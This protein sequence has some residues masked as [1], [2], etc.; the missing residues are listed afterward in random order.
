MVDFSFIEDPDLR[1][2]AENVAKIKIDQLTVDLSN[3]AKSQIEEAVAGLKAKNTEILTEKKTLQETLKK[4]EGYDPKVI[5]EATEFYE[6]NKDA[7]FLKDGTVEELIEKKTSQLTSDFEAQL[8]ELNE[9]LQKAQ[10]HG[11]TYQQLFEAKV[12]DDGIREEALKAGML[13]SAIE[14]AILRGRGIFSLDENKQIEA[15]DAEGKLAI[16]EDKKVLTTKNWIEGL[17]TTSPHY[18]PQSTSAN[19][20]GGRSGDMTDIMA[21]KIAAAE[22]GDVNAYR[23]LRDAKR[24]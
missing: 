4:F 3:S 1:E 7:E 17:K 24:K 13:P 16:T 6:K 12:I 21:K 15:R 8:N 14:D 23:K 5:K 10:H 9:S 22:S 19:A 11:K 2:K 18:W 20:Y